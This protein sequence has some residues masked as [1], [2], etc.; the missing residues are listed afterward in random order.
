MKCGNLIKTNIMSQI[1]ISFDDIRSTKHFQ[2]LSFIQKKMTL[3]KGNVM[4]I[5]NGLNI[6]SNI[7]FEKWNNQTMASY[8]NTQIIKELTKTKIK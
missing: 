8:R 7:G 2:S 1:N 4:A 3:E 5:Q 6:V